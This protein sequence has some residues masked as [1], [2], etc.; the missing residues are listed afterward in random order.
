MATTVERGNHVGYD[1]NDGYIFFRILTA[2]RFFITDSH[3][4]KLFPVKALLALPYQL[5]TAPGILIESLP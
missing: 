1:Y 5:K 2:N 3:S 4:S